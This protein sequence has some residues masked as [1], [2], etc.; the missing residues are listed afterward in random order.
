MDELKNIK[1]PQGNGVLPCVG[2]SFS[3]EKLLKTVA[4][5]DPEAKYQLQYTDYE[6]A[7]T[8]PSFI[9]GD[10]EMRVNYNDL[11]TD[12]QDAYFGDNKTLSDATR[13]EIDY[14]LKEAS[15]PENKGRF[16]LGVGG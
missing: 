9:I 16:K 3:F 6:D 10:K 5:V 8:M 13:R 4:S 14:Y 15:K 2:S 12:S 1:I 11:I 7:R